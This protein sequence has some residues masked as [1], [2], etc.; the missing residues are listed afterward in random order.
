MNEV[1]LAV[2]HNWAQNTVRIPVQDGPPKV[3][4]PE[5]RAAARKALCHVLF[6][7]DPIPET[8]KSAT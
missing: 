2:S 5:E 4:T 7:R 6:G 8:E 1:G 3:G